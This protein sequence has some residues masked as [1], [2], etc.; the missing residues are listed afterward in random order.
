M[1]RCLMIFTALSALLFSGATLS[2]CHLDGR[3]YE[4]GAIVAGYIC[5]DGN[6]E[7]L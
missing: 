2:E 1:N 4:E 3:I 7:E 5:K 6:W